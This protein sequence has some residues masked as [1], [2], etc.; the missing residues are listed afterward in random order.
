MRN[1]NAME[2]EAVSGGD[3]EIE[4]DT[5]IFRVL[6]KGDESPQQIATAIGAGIS[7]VYDSAVNAM[8]DFFTWLD[9]A[10]YYYGCR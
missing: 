6:V 4:L 1:L 3:Y 10:G 9:P 2:M 7:D 8:S 5:G